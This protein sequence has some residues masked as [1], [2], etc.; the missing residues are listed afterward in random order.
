[1]TTPA[2]RAP[3]FVVMDRNGSECGWFDAEEAALVQ[4]AAFDRHYLDDVPHLVH[5]IGPALPG[6]APVPAQ[7]TLGQVCGDTYLGTSKP[8]SEAWELAATAVIAAHEAGKE[9]ERVVRYAIQDSNGWWFTGTT[10]SPDV[11]RR[12]TFA[13]PEIARGVLEVSGC[14]SEYQKHTKIVRITTRRRRVV[15]S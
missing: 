8:A 9:T 15:K 5:P 13:S 6:P 7:K 11:S 3:K 10:A 4:A 14:H 12:A 1:M 2:N